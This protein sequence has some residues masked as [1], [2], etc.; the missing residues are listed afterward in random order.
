VDRDITHPLLPISRHHVT[1]F[2]VPISVFFVLF[3]LFL[4]HDCRLAC[5]SVHV[6]QMNSGIVRPPLE[7]VSLL[8]ERCG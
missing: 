6:L 3:F 7:L 8:I 4:R 1:L 2:S 5:T